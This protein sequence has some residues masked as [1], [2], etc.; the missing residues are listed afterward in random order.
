MAIEILGHGVHHDVR[1]ELDGALQIRAEEGVVHG[2][3]DAALV[4]DGGNGGDIGEDHGG[5]GGRLDV[6]HS[7]IRA[8]SRANS[9]GIGRVHKTELDAELAKKLRRQPIDAAV[10]GV[11]K[12]GVVA[13][14]Q[15][16]KH[17]VDG[18]HAGSKDVSRVA[19]LE[20]GHAALQ[21]APVG[22]LGAGVFVAFILSERLLHVRGGLKNR[23]DDG[24]RGGLRLLADMDRVG[25][26]SHEC[27]SSRSLEMACAKAARTVQENRLTIIQA[28]LL[29]SC[30]LF[31]VDSTHE[32]LAR[33]P[34]LRNPRRRSKE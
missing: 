12:N 13:G 1:A 14:T 6:D 19:S 11:G 23:G 28:I 3:G 27:S 24:A 2:D 17:G 7:R 20:A 16:P 33:L 15:Q 8:Q 32:A 18:R 21:S 5:I 31:V 26:E 30:L 34:R 29:E 22:M 25:G 9:L 10:D 4:G